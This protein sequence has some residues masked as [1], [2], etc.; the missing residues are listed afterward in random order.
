[1][2]TIIKEQRLVDNTKRALL[3]YVIL[4]DGTQDSNTTLVDVSSLAYSLNAN[5]YIMTGG[6]DPR[7]T[8][9]TT[10]K[11]VFGQVSSNIGHIRLQWHINGSNT[12]VLTIGSGSF[13]YDFHS[14]GDG[15]VIKN[16]DTANSSGDILYSTRNFLNNE[17][18][19]IFVDLRKDNTD[20]DAG[21][22]AD[23]TAFNRGPAAP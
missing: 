22:S 10:I 2:A 17:V 7:A 15:A 20:F 3:K 18:A 5:G 6:A 4:S 11:R 12:E 23:P 19:T 13:D 16:T 9:K 14:M 21:Q 8:Y 1:M